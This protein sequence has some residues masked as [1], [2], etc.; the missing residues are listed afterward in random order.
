M[1]A[2]PAVTLQGEDAAHG[3]GVARVEAE[4][5]EDLGDLIGIGTDGPQGCGGPD[6]QFDVFADEALQH[7]GRLR[8]RVVK[9]ERDRG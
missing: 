6:A 9:V 4:V 2:G 1:R 5:H 8:N 3:H 7:F